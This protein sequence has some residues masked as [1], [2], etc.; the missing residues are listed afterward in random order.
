MH[1]FSAYI[2]GR[3]NITA[4]YNFYK[5][6]ILDYSRLL[7]SNRCPRST[8]KRNYFDFHYLHIAF[9]SFLFDK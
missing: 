4:Q 7:L 2:L 8:T 1:V 3:E 5:K 9:S 6:Y